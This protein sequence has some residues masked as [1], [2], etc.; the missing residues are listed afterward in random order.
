MNEKEEEKKKRKKNEY[1]L[2]R[3]DV[4]LITVAPFM[5]TI[6][7]GAFSFLFFF[8]LSFFFSFFFKAQTGTLSVEINAR[9]LHTF[10]FLYVR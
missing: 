4:P 10:F 3:N 6:H 8:F 9:R 5:F 2:C 7:E 1:G